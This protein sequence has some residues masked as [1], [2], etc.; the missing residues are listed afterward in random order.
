[1]TQNDSVW[2]SLTQHDSEWLETTWNDSEWPTFF[3]NRYIV[4]FAPNFLFQASMA[5]L[6]NLRARNQ[7]GS[8]FWKGSVDLTMMSKY[9]QRMS[10]VCFWPN[11]SESKQPC[12][13]RVRRWSSSGYF[14]NTWNSGTFAESCLLLRRFQL[15]KVEGVRNLVEFG[16][17]I[18]FIVL[19]CA[20]FWVKMR[21][22]R[23]TKFL[24]YKAIASKFP[25]CRVAFWQ[26]FD[27]LE[28]SQETWADEWD[29][30]ERER[31]RESESETVCVFVLEQAMNQVGDC[32]ASLC[33]AQYSRALVRRKRSMTRCI[34]ARCSVLCLPQSLDLSAP[35]HRFHFLRDIILLPLCSSEFRPALHDIGNFKLADAWFKQLSIARQ[36]PHLG[37][38]IRTS[39]QRVVVTSL[40]PA[41]AS[42][43]V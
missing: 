9:V 18:C 15:W 8:D 17:L 4:F 7:D 21:Q 32:N 37:A 3:F 31:E 24:E 35:S 10:K 20:L 23:I 34:A 29:E 28:T 41:A 26:R 12:P 27:R 2:L 33:L 5:H 40:L 13:C 43:L 19:H 42:I 25:F 6:Q 36:C 39:S 11:D 14:G 16:V 30:I 38:A 1:M 22:L